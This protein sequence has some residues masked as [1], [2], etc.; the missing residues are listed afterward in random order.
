[1]FFSIGEGDAPGVNLFIPIGAVMLVVWTLPA[2]LGGAAGA[3]G[4]A[5]LSRLWAALSGPRSFGGA[6]EEKGK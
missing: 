6:G 3:L 4:S 2:L 5:A 1:L